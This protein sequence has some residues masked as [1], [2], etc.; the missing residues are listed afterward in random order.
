MA[1]GKD[2]ANMVALGLLIAALFIAGFNSY[3]L[4]GVGKAGVTGNIVNTNTPAAAAAAQTA[5]TIS[6]SV[7]PTGVPAIYGAELGVSFDDVTPANPQKADVT[8]KKL[9]ALD[10][11]ITLTTEQKARY[12]N[13]LY[14]LENGIA[15]E[16][17]CGARSVIFET[18]EAACGCAHS[19][20]MRGVTKYLLTE[21]PDEYTDAQILEEVGKWKT[22]FFPGV[23]AQKAQVL[24]QNGIELNYVNIASNKYRG[25][26][27][28]AQ[29]AG[30]GGAM[31]G[32]C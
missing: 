9:G 29:A 19:Y 6:F 5:Q 21:H 18:G 4:S 20:A 7:S 13:I 23:L 8:I 12:I 3:Q 14:K 24:Q 17:C 10:D 28:Q 31:V 2:E 27:N 26:E 30:S 22:L 16:Y 32:G 1:L 25:I 11:S 15:C